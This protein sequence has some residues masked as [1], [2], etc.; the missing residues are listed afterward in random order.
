MET[1]GNFHKSQPR[2]H[3]EINVFLAVVSCQTIALLFYVDFAR[4][5]GHMIKE[6]TSQNFPQ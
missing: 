3:I 6:G 1:N 2:N 4:L 5:F